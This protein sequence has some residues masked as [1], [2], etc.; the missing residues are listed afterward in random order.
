MTC[1]MPIRSSGF[2]VCP[3]QPRQNQS[4]TLQPH[5]EPPPVFKSANHSHTFR[6][7]NQLSVVAPP[8]SWC[9]VVWNKLWCCCFPALFKQSTCV[10]CTGVTVHCNRNSSHSTSDGD[11]H[12]GVARHQRHREPPLAPRQSHCL[13]WN[14]VGL[15]VGRRTRAVHQ[16]H[17]RMDTA[18][19][20]RSHGNRSFAACPVRGGTKR[21]GSYARNGVCGGHLLHG[22]W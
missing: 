7:S 13:P 22:A 8:S 6:G 3:K 21:S 16:R 14:E 1:S 12:A 4:A 11:R 9:E 5:I 10:S 20:K 15:D 2:L 19:R 18:V 17:G